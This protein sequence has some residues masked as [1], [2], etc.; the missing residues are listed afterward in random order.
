M[1]LQV[2]AK[3]K[4]RLHTRRRALRQGRP[5][6]AGLGGSD[7]RNRVTVHALGCTRQAY[8]HSTSCAVNQYACLISPLPNIYLGRH[9]ADL[10]HFPFALLYIRT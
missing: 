1:I 5:G 2:E 6:G 3:I 4:T 10:V 7:G 8:I 9:S